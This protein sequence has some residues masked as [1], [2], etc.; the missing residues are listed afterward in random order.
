[1]LSENDPLLIDT[2]LINPDI[3]ISRKKVYYS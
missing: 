2:V 1:M 3:N